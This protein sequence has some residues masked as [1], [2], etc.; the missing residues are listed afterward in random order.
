MGRGRTVVRAFIVGMMF[1]SIGIIGI[2]VGVFLDSSWVQYASSCVGLL[3]LGCATYSILYA[4]D[5]N[6]DP[7][8][9]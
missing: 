7:R 3:G 2:I 8:S 1:G 4:D 9:S 6:D 5:A